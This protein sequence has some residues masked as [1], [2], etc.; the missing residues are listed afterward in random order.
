MTLRMGE[1]TQIT[2]HINAAG[3]V[4]NSQLPQDVGNFTE[5]AIV[6]TIDNPYEITEGFK[7]K[8]V[9]GDKL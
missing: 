1:I 7:M 3:I 8:A 2:F 4:V 5:V 6:G 9:T